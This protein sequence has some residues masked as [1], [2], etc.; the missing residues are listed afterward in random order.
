MLGISTVRVNRTLQELRRLKLAD[1]VKNELTV[2]DF[3]RLAD[4][5]EF[6]ADYLA[7]LQSRSTVDMISADGG[8]SSRLALQEDGDQPHSRQ[9]RPGFI[10]DLDS[11]AV[12]NFA[13]PHLLR[14]D[15]AGTQLGFLTSGIQ[16]RK[17]L[18]FCVA[19]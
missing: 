13:I 16:V 2:Y 4:L 14:K 18:A 15:L 6:D 3:E 10:G 7:T 9:K 5:G 17:I 11:I 19:D 12:K 1:I 8:V